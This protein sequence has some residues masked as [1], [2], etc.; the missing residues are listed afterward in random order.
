MPDTSQGPPE[1]ARNEIEIL[2]TIGEGMFGTVYR[3]RCRAKDVAVKV[4]HRHLDEANLQAFRKEIRIVRYYNFFFNFP[5]IPYFYYL[6][7]HFSF[8]LVKS[9]I[10][11]LFCLWVL[12]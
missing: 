5:F 6:F 4:L 1:I 9:F 3:G 12:V 2:E 10:Q 11:I 7:I 8:L